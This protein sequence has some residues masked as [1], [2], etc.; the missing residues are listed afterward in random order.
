MKCI[1]T[2]IS[3][4]ACAGLILSAFTGCTNNA[5]EFVDA[6][7]S[8]AVTTAEAEAEARANAEAAKNAEAAAN[9]VAAANETAAYDAANG[10]EE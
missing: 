7:A 8:R 6:V 4:V 9:A 5:D 3:V 2:I 1:K 10:A